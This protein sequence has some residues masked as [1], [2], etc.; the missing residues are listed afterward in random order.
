MSEAEE[1]EIKDVGH[2]SARLS[3]SARPLPRGFPYPARHGTHIKHALFRSASLLSVS[4][5]LRS[6]E[7]LLHI[8]LAWCS[9]R[10]TSARFSTAV[11]LNVV[12]SWCTSSF[13]CAPLWDE[14][15]LTLMILTTRIC[16]ALPMRSLAAPVALLGLQNDS[17]FG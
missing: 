8:R 12:V 11:L 9:C 5:R 2:L 6:S 3:S 15:E 13:P 16:I 17:L 4:P 1:K 7:P 14:R 10:K